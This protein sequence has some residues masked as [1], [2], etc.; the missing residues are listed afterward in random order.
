MAI[1]STRTPIRVTAQYRH[2]PYLLPGIRF[3]HHYGRGIARTYD[4]IPAPR[5]Y[6]ADT[7]LDLTGDAAD[8][9]AAAR[10]GYP[11]NGIDILPPFTEWNW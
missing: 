9:R 2:E 10:N 5:T 8:I 4:T 1:Q 7:A 6:D 3:T 11:P